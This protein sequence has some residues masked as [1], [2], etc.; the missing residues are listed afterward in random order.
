LLNTLPPTNKVTLPD[1][2]K[3]KN[4]ALR[5]NHPYALCNVYGHYSHHCI[6]LPWFQDALQALRQLAISS[7]L[8][9]PLSQEIEVTVLSRHDQFFQAADKARV[10][11][12]PKSPI[13]VVVAD[14]NHALFYG[15]SAHIE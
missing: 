10:N 12:A 1:A 4:K 14:T 6:N 3:N 13:A 2:A 8:E 11:T 7:A 15:R 9:P 5:T